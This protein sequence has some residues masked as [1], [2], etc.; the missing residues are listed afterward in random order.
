MILKVKIFEY[1]ISNNSVI[2]YYTC[3]ENNN[4]DFNKLSKKCPASEYLINA[5]NCFSQ[6]SITTISIKIQTS[7]TIP[8][9]IIIRNIKELS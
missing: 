6:K 9:S 5:L 1:Y 3:T 2:N 8:F 4:C 7:K